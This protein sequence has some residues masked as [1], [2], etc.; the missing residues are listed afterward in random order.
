M[1]SS[2]ETRY[3]SNDI[4]TSSRRAM[5]THLLTSTWCDGSLNFE[6]LKAR[7]WRWCFKPRKQCTFSGLP[8]TTVVPCLTSQKYRGFSLSKVNN[9][10]CDVTKFTLCLSCVWWV[11]MQGTVALKRP[12][13]A[14]E[15]WL[16]TRYKCVTSAPTCFRLH[17][18]RW[19][20]LRVGACSTIFAQPSDLTRMDA[21]W[22]SWAAPNGRWSLQTS[23]RSNCTRT[24][25]L[26]A[27]CSFRLKWRTL[28]MLS[29]S[30]PCSS[31][32]VTRQTVFPAS[33]IQRWRVCSQV[34]DNK[35]PQ[36]RHS[37]ANWLN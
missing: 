17:L 23:Q 26:C 24:C 36:W 3:V 33:I 30:L 4:M 37:R 11:K 12:S 13:F 25:A 10:S 6:N 35:H 18:R 1:F 2:T 8:R 9:T 21:Q 31:E 7:K 32:W 22:K 28:W 29:T 27:K 34:S 19:S 14:R 20:P 16:R 15:K 5:T